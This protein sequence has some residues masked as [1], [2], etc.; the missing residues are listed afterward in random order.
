MTEFARK[1]VSLTG[2]NYDE[3]VIPITIDS[4]AEY[5]VISLNGPH[6]LAG[7]LSAGSPLF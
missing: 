2:K 6:N 4:D 5:P 7:K 1:R 3:I